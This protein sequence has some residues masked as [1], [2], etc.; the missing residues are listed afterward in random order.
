MDDLEEQYRHAIEIA[1]RAHEAF[2]DDAL[3]A[4]KRGHE[5]LS[6][7]FKVWSE[8]TQNVVRLARLMQARGTVGPSLDAELDELLGSAE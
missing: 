4:T 2:L 3:V 8:A 5:T 1:N 7:W 6:P